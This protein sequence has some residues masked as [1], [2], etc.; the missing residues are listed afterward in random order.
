MLYFLFHCPEL[1]VRAGEEV[2]DIV[3]ES[4]TGCFLQTFAGEGST[5]IK[6]CDGDYIH[7]CVDVLCVCVRV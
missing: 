2:T 6:P 1:C 5:Q 3:K 7:T 4:L